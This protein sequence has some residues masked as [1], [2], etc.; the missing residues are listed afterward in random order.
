LANHLIH[1]GR[2]REAFVCFEKSLDLTPRAAVYFFDYANA[3]LLYRT[4][5]MS[6]Y[7]L[8]EAEVFDRVLTNCRRGLKLEPESFA[9][10]VQ[11]AQNYYVVKPARPAEGLAAWE[12]AFQ[13]AQNDT[14]RDEARTH[15]A[16]YAIQAGR[17]GVAR[18]HLDLVHAPHLEPVKDALLRRIN[19]VAKASPAP[20]K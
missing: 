8:T 11:L 1:N 3:L 13:L 9:F 20:R 14:Q 15:L 4:E 12:H 10:A 5:A 18:V 6:H 7:R 19:E 16:R 2:V 17:F